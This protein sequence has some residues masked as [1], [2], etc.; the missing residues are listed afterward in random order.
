MLTGELL[1]LSRRL[2]VNP[3][4]R[5]KYPRENAPTILKDLTIGVVA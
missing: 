3:F 1:R 4:A 2:V 5:L